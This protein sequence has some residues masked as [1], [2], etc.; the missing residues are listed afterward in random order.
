MPSP[1]LTEAT[2]AYTALKSA[3]VDA[4]S[5]DLDKCASLLTTAKLALAKAG[6]L[7]VVD[8]SKAASLSAEL[9]VAR[10]I[11]EI[12]AL[13]S[14]HAHSIPDFERYFS[15]LLPYYT[16]LAAA[17]P[18]PS[19]RHRM[20]R[21]LHLLSLLAQSRIAEFHAAL[22][23]IP[24]DWVD[25]EDV[26]I[27]HA[28]RLEQAL[29]EGAYNKVWTARTQVPCREATW[30][31]ELLMGTIRN[32]IASCAE[33]SYT[34]LPMQDVA[35]LLFFPAGASQLPEVRDFCAERGWSIAGGAVPVV[36]FGGL[37]AESAAIDAHAVIRDVIGYAREIER[38]V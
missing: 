24:A 29:M 3:F 11:L 17:I 7:V 34:H 15:Q 38:I 1:A 9:T 5:P 27:A 26:Y 30:F 37:E 10:E 33:R 16:D 13:Y 8:P 31:V 35:T 28:V 21:G 18:T 20:L 14:I 19:P 23:R 6:A 36:Q 25:G 22:E 4:P 32:E 2:A 12:G